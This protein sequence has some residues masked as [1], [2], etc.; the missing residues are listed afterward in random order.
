MRMQFDSNFD[1]DEK[2]GEPVN[3]LKLTFIIVFFVLMFYG[4]IFL[5]FKNSGINKRKL[6]L[7]FKTG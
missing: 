1:P 7:S 2:K 5:L 3:L 6:K 4:A